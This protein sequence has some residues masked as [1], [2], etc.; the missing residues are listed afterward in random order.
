MGG[1]LALRYALLY[2]GSASKIIAC[3]MPGMTSLEA[4][5][6]KWRSRISQFRAEGVENLAVATVERWFPDPCPEGVKEEAL[7]MTRQCSLTG[8]EICAEAIMNYDY[9]G[10][11][12]NLKPD[13][14]KVMVL[15]GENDEAVGP[16]EILRG[17]AA[18]VKGSE[19]VVVKDAGHLPPMHRREE[20]ERIMLEFLKR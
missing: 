2:P 20:F 12:Q 13:N 11:L 8:Y 19:Y 16:V 7:T 1:V 3:D 10:E 15:V 17:V 4:A 5:K 9:E 14:Q 6:P 18:K